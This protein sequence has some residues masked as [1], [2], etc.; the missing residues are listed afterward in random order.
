[1]LQADYSLRLLAEMG[2]DVY[3]PR[4]AQAG[5]A[6]DP[7]VAGSDIAPR[8]VPMSAPLDVRHDA[9]AAGEQADAA[10][11]CVENTAEIIL[12][13]A[14]GAGARVLAD[15][16][17]SVRMMGW[18]VRLTDASELAAGLQ[19]RALVVLGEPLARE[20]GAALPAQRQRAV[21]WIVA[22]EP[23]ALARSA[24]AKRALWGEFKRIARVLASPAP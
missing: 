13:H 22:A 20:L 21:E 12:L 1:M 2:V 19:V 23:V 10:S 8:S 15:V 7:P 4:R 14:R 5:A 18:S 16:E 6:E 9:A 3:L 24:A 17:R 11:L